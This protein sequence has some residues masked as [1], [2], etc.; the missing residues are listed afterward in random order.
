M[1]TDSLHRGKVVLYIIGSYY[2]AACM[3]MAALDSVHR[4]PCLQLM[5]WNLKR[6]CGC[7][8]NLR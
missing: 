7:Y 3:G 4:L 5:E 2:A 1:D 8:H 6:G